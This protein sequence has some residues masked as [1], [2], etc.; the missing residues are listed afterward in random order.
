MKFIIG[1][2][3]EQSV[4]FPDYLDDYV[5]GDS[6]ARVI[7]AY[8]NSL[9]LS[10]LNFK[11]TEPKNTGRPPYD[12][13]D[14]LK[15]YV[16]GYMN[17]I[18]SSRRLE[19]ECKRN[20]ELIWLM[21]KLAPDYKTISDFRK[22]NCK[23]LKNV[24]HNFVKLC[25]HLGLYGKE[26]VAID[27]SKFKAVNSKDRNFTK[28]KLEERLKRIDDKIEEYLKELNKNDKEEALLEKEKTAQEI[29]KII[30]E[31]KARKEVYQGYTKELEKSGQ[32]QKSLTD[33]D[34]RLMPSN[35]KMDVCYNIQTAVDSMHKLIAEF[36]VTNN[37]NDMN[38]I[39]PMMQ[40]VQETLETQT[41]AAAADAGYASASDIAAAIRL[42]VEPHVAG[43]DF[44]ICIPVE[45]TASSE[46]QKDSSAEAEVTSHINGRCI[47]VKERNISI[48]PMGKV[49][50]PGHYKESKGEA[51]FHNTE[52]CK[53][54]TCRCTK[55]EGAFRYQFVM[56]KDD[57][58]QEYND[59]DLTVK[60]IHIKPKKEIYE[61]RKSIVEHPF[62]TIKRSM[63]G[64]YCLLK[65]K[66]KV[67]GEF[68]LTFLAYN[69][70]RVINIMGGKK[71]IE[72]IVKIA[73]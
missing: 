16:Y 18:R 64:S 23:A 20:L 58:S 37:A 19:T 50:Y 42:G 72:N 56:N 55:Q 22:D 60:Q 44:D 51:V 43:T 71:I 29:E 25:M 30:K 68:S 15:L 34:S 3:R 35:G 5:D 21:C 33:S 46:G 17:R 39:T 9:D 38:Q 26:L 2:E 47:Y 24:F 28:A 36:E 54:C 62:G 59:E 49:L 6:A 61:Q 27:G 32:T 41:I 53:T 4:L 12:P 67:K 40:Q 7:E 65:G 1:E 31:L 73:G 10:L 57:F 13:K 66:E 11:R 63:D 8:I 48:C 45:D 69:L 70:K 14:L 52:A